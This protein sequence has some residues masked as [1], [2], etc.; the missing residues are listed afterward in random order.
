M[1]IGDPWPAVGRLLEL[2]TA[3]RQDAVDPMAATFDDVPYWGDIGRLLALYGLI[4][5]RR[6]DDARVL[7][8]RLYTRV[9]DVLVDDRLE[10]LD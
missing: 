6:S 8:K 2:E 4:R 5:R 7:K 9:F 1:P 10:G 3:I